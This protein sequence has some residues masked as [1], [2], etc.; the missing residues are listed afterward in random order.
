MEIVLLL[1]VAGGGYMFF[2]SNTRRGAESVRSYV[3]LGGIAAGA[4]VEEANH[5]ASFNTVQAPPNVIQ[6]AI[7]HCRSAYGGKTLAMIS[8]AYGQGMRPKLPMW[9]QRL[10]GLKYETHSRSSAAGSMN[11]IQ[12]FV[13]YYVS[14]ELMNVE[15]GLW[16]D[17]ITE[18]VQGEVSIGTRKALERR[19]KN[20]DSYTKSNIIEF[21]ADFILNNVQKTFREVMNDFNNPRFMKEFFVELDKSSGIKELYESYLS[22][23]LKMIRNKYGEDSS[24]TQAMG[25]RFL[26]KTYF[27]IRFLSRN[28][29]TIDFFEREIANFCKGKV[30]GYE[31]DI[32]LDFDKY[33]KSVVKKIKN[34]DGKSEEDLHWFELMDSEG[35]KKAYEDGVNAKVLSAA[36]LARRV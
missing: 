36:V 7:A 8:E 2:K 24:D 35:T 19:I 22:W 3:F 1:L 29:K 10:M 20:Y 25:R 15:E 12:P 23:G 33:E 5:V 26:I 9:E 31:T 13:L 4:S 11:D 32:P 28:G 17:S 30:D 14:S 27:D 18:I 16:S 21:G 34:M 6:A